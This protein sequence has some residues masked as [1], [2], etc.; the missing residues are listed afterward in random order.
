MRPSHSF[1]PHERRNRRIFPRILL[2]LLL[3]G[4]L[5]PAGS[6]SARTRGV[7]IEDFEAG[8][9]ALTGYPEQD[10]E[11][12]DWQVTSGNP[13]GG[14]GSSLRLFGNTWKVQAVT[15]PAV[16]DSTVWQV[17]VYCEN[18]G[19]MQGLGL[20]DGQNEL[21]Y[22]FFGRDLPESTNWY[23]VYQG[24]FPRGQWHLFLLPVGQDW[25][26]RFGYLP[27]LDR[28]VYVNDCDAGAPGVTLFDAVADVTEDLPRAPR[29]RILYT[30]EKQDRLTDKLYRLDVQFHG[31]VFDPD[32]GSH[33]WAWDFG[34]S[35]GS[36]QQD[37]SHEFLV[38]ADYPYTVGL[39]VTDP[40]GL[41]AGDT[42]QVAV[43][44]GEPG[45]LLTVNFVGDIFTGRGYENSGGIID[46]YGVEALFTP[47][48]DILGRAAD[49]N[50]ANLEVSY[51]D[52]GT[53]HPTKSVVFRS[54]PENI[55]G[56]AYAGIDVVT[57]GN[58]HI[59]DYGEIGMLDTIDGL[60]QLGIPYCGA[61]SS[62]YLALLPAFR[63]EKGVRLG[64]LGLCNRTGRQWNFQ[65]FLD[66]GYDKPGFAYLLPENLD[67]AISYTLPLADIVIVQTHSGDEYQTAP[68]PDGKGT[69]RPGGRPRVEAASLD[70]ADPE[71]RFR[72]EPTPGE[73]ELRRLALDLGADVLINHHPH[74]LQGFESYRGKL[75]AHSLGNFVFDL[76]YPET[77]P[78][79]V[80]TLEM[81]KT[82]ITGYRFTPAWINHWI[83]RP[84]T[85]NLG[86]EIIGRMADYSRPMNAVV[87]PLAGRDEARIHLSRTGL[88]STVTTQEMELP[89]VEAD[90][91]VQ[92]APV[93]LAGQGNLSEIVA[94]AAD[95][96][97]EVRWGREILWHGGFE[98]EGADLWD[99][100][101]A[102]EVL[103]TD[104]AHRGE[105]SLRLR[106]LS[107][108]VGQ[109]GTDLEKHLPCD[110]ARRH[111]A[112]AWLRADNAAQARVM[113]RFYPTRSAA[114]PVAD[115]DLAPR[116]DG[117]TDWVRQWRDL[118]T[119][120]NALYFE[121]RCGHEPPAEGTGYSW[122]DDLAL[123][124]WEPWMDASVDLPVPA[125]NNYRFLQV[126]AAAT[127]VESV[128]VSYR[129]TS[130]G[131]GQASPAPQEIPAATGLSLR[132]FPNP[133]NPRTT[134]EL[135][136]V[137]GKRTG[138]VIV[139]IF[140]LRGRRVRTL[141]RGPVPAGLRFGMTWDGRDDRGHDL[142]SGIYLV[143]ARAGGLSAGGKVTLV[144]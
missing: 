107:G 4:C 32:S 18:L 13:Y 77:M 47:T 39:R 83:P 129:E 53:P 43:T 40:D 79:L 134:V 88:D 45:E 128:A 51:T 27:E 46:T 126:R 15:P 49:V 97:W 44:P 96:A 20:G 110:P 86:R 10:L 144:R 132:C 19:E 138:E 102:D 108:A 103:V 80:L 99:V 116:L 54:E 33:A 101:T 85:G 130:Y 122:Y 91:Y 81:E 34:D 48:L 64:F 142:A 115:Y 26:D 67:Q 113:V 56:I 17:A 5:I 23:T 65:P 38:Q 95:G 61:G 57:I 119:P 35:T 55:A 135:G 106:R 78:T 73:R 22:T 125:P 12:D 93:E 7:P 41:V 24:A 1:G 59:I 112:V 21:F 69:G 42:C 98:D 127:G 62:E 84:A 50:V 72:V 25:L 105:R 104:V 11:P 2:F 111:S 120:E 31:E 76:Y 52:R 75:I 92:S 90:G 141:F 3:C 66:A 74:V 109:T 8:V 16:T 9:P 60:K 114:T 14:S 36:D 131:P 143:R 58:N 136:P 68:P 121:L 133:C 71:F 117:S 63:T 28:L 124:E 70:P 82:G 30:V 123:I 140:D 29:V 137:A 89:L 118:E 87:V 6:S 139:E 100:N 37:P 94:P